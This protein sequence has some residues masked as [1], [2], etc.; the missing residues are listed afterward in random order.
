MRTRGEI[1]INNPIESSTTTI[2]LQSSRILEFAKLTSSITSHC[3]EHQALLSLHDLLSNLDLSP[4]LQHYWYTQKTSI[5]SEHKNIV[6]KSH[7]L[8]IT[9]DFVHLADL[10][11]LK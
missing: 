11:K 8:V 5:I 9:A 3:R 2:I 4:G 10:V 1:F 7:L 6:E